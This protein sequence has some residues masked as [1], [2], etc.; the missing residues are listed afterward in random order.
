M[1]ILCFIINA[2]F[3]CKDFYYNPFEQYEFQYT[4][5]SAKSVFLGS[6]GNI[7]LFV[8][9]PL[10]VDGWKWLYFKYQSCCNYNRKYTKNSNTAKH[11]RDNNSTSSNTS[12]I[13]IATSEYQ[14]LLAV[15]KRPKVKWSNDIVFETNDSKT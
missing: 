10:I 14:R 6:Y 15:H 5:I 4:E 2:Y 1:C 11:S 9:K 7:T 8:S 12:G 13:V 3:S